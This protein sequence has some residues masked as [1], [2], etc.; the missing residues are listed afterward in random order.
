MAFLH[1]PYDGSK[2][3]FSVGLEPIG[4][5]D[6]LE[7]DEAFLSQL[8]RKA[9]LI[10]SAHDTVFQAKEDTG[11]AQ[12]EVLNLVLSN[13]RAREEVYPEWRDGLPVVKDETGG[14]IPAGSAGEPDLLT[15]ARFIQEDLVLMRKGE[16]GYTLAAACL[17]FPSSWSLLEK[18]GQSMHGIHENVP[19]FN[20][21]RMGQVVARIFEN[22]KCEQLLARYN[23]SIYDTPELH[24]PKPKSLSPQVLDG[25]LASLGA[26]FI[27]VERQTLRRLPVSGDILFTIKIHHDPIAHLIR[28]PRCGALAGSLRAQLLNL[29]SDQ[30][31][32][33]GLTP[34]RDALAG[35]L[36]HMVETSS[37]HPA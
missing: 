20:N 18:F 8:R 37:M 27:R 28:D 11:A 4:V 19:D 10:E 14:K 34:F 5:S 17:C 33:K 31:A 6:W 12:G 3:P 2:Q 29:S 25:S 15:A 1:T 22:L 23:W 30:L 35:A 21:A 26:L 36:S 9:E 32:C 7:T 16:A 13:L 24:H